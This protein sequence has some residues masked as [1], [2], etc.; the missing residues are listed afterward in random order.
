MSVDFL[1]TRDAMVG[2]TERSL[3]QRAIEA[4]QRLFNAPPPPPRVIPPRPVSPFSPTRVVEANKATIAKVVERFPLKPLINSAT[5]I[6]EVA[7]KHG[8]SVEDVTGDS[9]R[10]HHVLA[11]REAAYRLVFELGLSNAGAGKKLNRDHSTIL[12]AIRHHLREHPEL[13]PEADHKVKV[14]SSLKEEVAKLYFD[15]GY[16]TTQ[17]MHELDIDRNLVNSFIRTEVRR[18]RD[19]RRL[20]T[21][22]NRL[23]I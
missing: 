8:V 10:P 2:A 18:V 16:T 19:E 14:R 4:R 9:R 3:R 23:G 20:S 5:I 12:W 6:S 21:G 7:Q 1:P 11:R 15:D 13:R 17:I 22:N